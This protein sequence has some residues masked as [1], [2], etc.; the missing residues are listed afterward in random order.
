MAKRKRTNSDLKNTTEIN[1]DRP[2][3]TTLKPGINSGTPDGSR[4]P[5]LHVSPIV[6]L[7]DD[8]IWKEIRVIPVY[9]NKNK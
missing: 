1:K 3:R 8:I 9:V 4:V 7:L 2:T 6:L 5:A